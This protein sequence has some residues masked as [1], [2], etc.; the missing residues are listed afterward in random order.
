MESAVETFESISNS[1][2]IEIKNQ[3]SSLK[4]SNRQISEKAGEITTASEYFGK[5]N[6]EL[7]RNNSELE[8][9]ISSLQ[10]SSKKLEKVTSDSE[11]SSDLLTGFNKKLEIE[12]E[13]IQSTSELYRQSL[14]DMKNKLKILVEIT[15]EFTSAEEDI[16]DISKKI[17]S[18][19][20]S[21]EGMI[22]TTKNFEEKINV[23][24]IDDLNDSIEAAMKAILTFKK[25]L[26]DKT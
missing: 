10:S 25:N 8:A 26:E 5:L 18:A 14:D 21:L 15:K 13:E 20:I 24:F 19:D 23:K 3:I 4:D 6:T 16:K 12:T 17:E 9:K 11:K 2:N 22:K 7:K 1:S